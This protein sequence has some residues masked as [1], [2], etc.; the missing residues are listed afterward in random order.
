MKHSNLRNSIFYLIGLLGHDFFYFAFTLYIIKFITSALFTGADGHYTDTMVATISGAIVTIRVVELVLDPFLGALIDNTKS[1]FGRYKPWI[2]LGGVVCSSSFVLLFTTLGGTNLTHPVLYLCMFLVLFLIMDGSY[3]LYDIAM[4]SMIPAISTTYEERNRIGTVARLGAGIGQA[5][6]TI[7]VMPSII[8][9]KNLFGSEQAGWLFFAIIVLVCTCLTALLT[10]IGV[11]EHE[12]AID[13]PNEKT[14]FTEVFSV[15]FKN[16]QL[17]WLALPNWCYYFSLAL[18]STLMTYYFQYVY[19]NAASYSTIFGTATLVVVVSILFYPWLTR[20]FSRKQVLFVALSVMI[21]SLAFFTFAGNNTVMV[22]IA[23]VLFLLP[24]PIIFTSFLLE[25]TDT[26][27][28][29]QWKSGKRNASITLA[30]R[31]LLDKFAGA[32]SNGVVGLVAL[33]CGMTGAASIAD[34]TSGNIVVFKTIMCGLPIALLLLSMFVY[35][36]KF[37]LNTAFHAQI[38]KDLE[39]RAAEDRQDS[40]EGVEDKQPQKTMVEQ[41]I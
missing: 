25:L 36:K 34:I 17:A 16:D 11:K 18:V 12:S 33:V 14:K 7:F 32:L 39:Q 13:T 9:G 31:P 5:L 1:R 28:Y 10:C 27:D 37:K 30:V 22:V 3:S 26:I 6:L 41:A 24:Q 40:A 21:V 2:M 38:M 8:L 23:S 29:G 20:R 15:I 35:Q 4:W 19:G